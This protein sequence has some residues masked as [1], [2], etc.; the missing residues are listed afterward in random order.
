MYAPH[1]VDRVIVVVLDG[2]RSDAIPLFPLR[3]L[4]ALAPRGAWTLRGETVQPSI[5]AAALTSLLTGVDPRVHG[6]RS[7]HHVVTRSVGVL[8]P[9]PMVLAAEGI[10]TYCHLAALPFYARGIGARVAAKLG[11]MATFDGHDADDIVSA[12]LG[13]IGT[14]RRG[15][16]MVHLPDADHAGHAQGWMSGAYRAAAQRVDRAFERLVHQ[17]GVMDDPGTV[18]VALADHG[19]GGIDPHHHNSTHPLDT[20]IPIMMLGARVAPRELAPGTS[21]VDIAATIPRLLG[22]EPPACYDGRVLLQPTMQAPFPT[23]R[24]HRPAVAA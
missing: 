19:G 12:A 6:V 13:R 2:I 5:T 16:V 20:T 18:L 4:R 3:G 15:L 9:L 1:A 23:Q 8:H 14:L 7:D 11:A 21:I 10:S 22:V 24:L 17:T